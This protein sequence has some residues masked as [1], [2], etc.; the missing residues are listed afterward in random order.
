[1]ITYVVG[2]YVLV[3][4]R[5]KTWLKLKLMW[6]GFCWL[7]D[8]DVGWV[9]YYHLFLSTYNRS[10]VRQVVTAFAIVIYIYIGKDTINSGHK[11]F[12]CSILYTYFQGTTL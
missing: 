12:I 1:M 4:R 5:G 11:L 10:I 7:P 9:T 6:N 3:E 8:V 2:N